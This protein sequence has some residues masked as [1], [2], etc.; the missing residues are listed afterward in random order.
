[1]HCEEMYC[2]VWNCTAMRGSVMQCDELEC[3]LRTKMRGEE[4]LWKVNVMECKEE[5]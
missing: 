5:M 2:N 1:M 4:M 3:N